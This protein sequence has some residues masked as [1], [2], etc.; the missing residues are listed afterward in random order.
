MGKDE[1]LKILEEIGSVD[2]VEIHPGGN[3]YIGLVVSETG[4]HY[5]YC[6]LVYF[7]NSATSREL[8]SFC[9]APED[10]DEVRVDTISEPDHGYGDYRVLRIYLK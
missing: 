4:R 5:L 10:V 2:A 8:E 9:V 3:Q 6:N 1:F 7:E